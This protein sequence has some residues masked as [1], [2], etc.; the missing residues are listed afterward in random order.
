MTDSC[1]GFV[2]RAAEE[3]STSIIRFASDCN[4][5]AIIQSRQNVRDEKD[6]KDKRNAKDCRACERES[7]RSVIHGIYDLRSRVYEGG[8][9]SQ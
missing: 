5:R 9:N 8:S 3:G 1:G 7:G 4:A 2:G 6:A